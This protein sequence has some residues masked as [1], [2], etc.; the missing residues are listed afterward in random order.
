MKVIGEKVLIQVEKQPDVCT[1]KV[2]GLT[3]PVGPSAGEY[4]VAEVIQVGEKVESVS[5]GDKIYLYYGSGKKFI[6]EGKEYRVITLSEI[7]VII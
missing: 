3:I 7:I 1:Q 5:V 2:G 6:H 4:E